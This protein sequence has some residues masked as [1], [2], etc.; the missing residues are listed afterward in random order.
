MASR[1][2]DCA[3]GKKTQDEF[4]RFFQLVP[5]LLCVV[6]A[7]GHFHRLNAKWSRAPGYTAAEL[8][9]TPFLDLVHADDRQATLEEFDRGFAHG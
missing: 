1:V 2:V 8:A 4:E 5:D 9:N 6:S 3:L 7:D